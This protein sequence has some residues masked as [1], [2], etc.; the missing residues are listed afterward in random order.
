LTATAFWGQIYEHVDYKMIYYGDFVMDSREREVWDAL[1]SYSGNLTD[2]QLSIKNNAG[3]EILT[4]IAKAKCSVRIISPYI[5]TNQIEKLFDKYRDVIDIIKLI[6]NYQQDDHNT[7]QKE[8]IK[9]LIFPVKETTGTI[10]YN[11]LFDTVVCKG[12]SKCFLHEKLYLIDDSVAYLGSLNFTENGMVSKYET[13]LKIENEKT[14]K[15]LCEYY[16]KL[17]NEIRSKWDAAEIRQ[18]LYGDP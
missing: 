8:A 14:V 15:S 5:S 3:E 4:S 11:Y 1:P 10:K 6:T 9:K 17:F 7:T 13:C 18:I 12:H 2:A 16:D